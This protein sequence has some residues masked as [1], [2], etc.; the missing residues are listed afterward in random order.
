[1]VVGGGVNRTHKFRVWAARALPKEC[2]VPVHGS[3]AGLESTGDGVSA[4]MRSSF[5]NRSRECCRGRVGGQ[6]MVLRVLRTEIL[7]E[8]GK[9][10][11]RFMCV[12]P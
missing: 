1:M 2:P 11:Q 6:G 3:G 8:M 10:E 12:S 7:Q 4:A 9:C 5:A